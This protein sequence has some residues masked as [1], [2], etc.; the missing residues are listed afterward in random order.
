M[1]G[2]HNTCPN[3]CTLSAKNAHA[4][5][6]ARLCN[7]A[8]A[9]LP[10]KLLRTYLESCAS[11]VQAVVCRP[12]H[13]AAVS[14]KSV[15]RRFSLKKSVQISQI[16]CRQIFS[17]ISQS[18]R[19]L[20]KNIQSTKSIKMDIKHTN[21]SI[22]WN[23][24]HDFHDFGSW[25]ESC[26]FSRAKFFWTSLRFFADKIYLRS[27]RAQGAYTKTYRVQ[28]LSKW[29]QNTQ[30]TRYYGTKDTIFMILVLGMRVVISP[31][32]NVLDKSQIFLPTKFI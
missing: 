28:N 2:A 26:D 4:R 10:L 24:R 29:T 19:C 1:H 7:S 11:I 16:L 8:E 30:I 32:L 13:P 6:H 12:A 3:A 25:D 20:Y 23:E 17:Q 9:S 14:T 31:E 27:R 21:N 22:L 5:V 18:T 15:T